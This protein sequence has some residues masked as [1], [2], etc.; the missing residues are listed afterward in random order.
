MFYVI[1]T[2]FIDLPKTR[3]LIPLSIGIKSEDGRH[4]Y[5]EFT[6]SD[7]SLAGAWIKEHVITHLDKG[8]SYPCIKDLPLLTFVVGD[9]EAIKNSLLEFFRDDK[10]PL[11]W[12]NF[13]DCDWVIFYQIFG[14]MMTLPSGFPHMCYDIRQY[15]NDFA[16]E[17]E[18]IFQ[19]SDGVTKYL[20][21]IPVYNGI[22][23]HALLDAKWEMERLLYLKEMKSLHHSFLRKK[24]K[25][26]LI[27]SVHSTKDA[28]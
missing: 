14:T 26:P 1:D 11:F 2:E 3:Q 21:K 28:N 25:K 17:L 19:N 13:A 12:G 18:S 16:E 9:T 8:S 6:D 5:A 20:S 27:R 23:H 24:I 10:R 15:Q 22:R 7:R 4:F